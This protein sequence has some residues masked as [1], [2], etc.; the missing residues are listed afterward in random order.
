MPSKIP[1]SYKVQDGCH[2]CER[3]SRFGFLGEAP[4]CGINSRAKFPV[5]HIAMKGNKLDRVLERWEKWSEGRI[6]NPAG[7]CE[8]WKAREK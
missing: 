5:L 2:N 7:K 1:K 6:V 8:K 3:A 4:R